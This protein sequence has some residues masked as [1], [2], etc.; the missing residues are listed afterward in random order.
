MS[1]GRFKVASQALS[2]GMA[3][4]MPQWITIFMRKDY[5]TRQDEDRA[6]KSNRH[7]HEA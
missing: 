4:S 5:A 3:P 7:I 6:L 1:Q 2:N